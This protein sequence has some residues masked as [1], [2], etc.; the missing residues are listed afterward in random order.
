MGRPTSNSAR[1]TGVPPPRPS[2]IA[3]ARLP[4]EWV[5]RGDATY[6]GVVATAVSA[7]YLRCEGPF[8]AEL[9]DGAAW[10]AIRIEFDGDQEWF[11]GYV[12]I[13]ALGRVLEKSELYGVF[14]GEADSFNGY[15]DD[16]CTPVT[17]ED[18]SEAW[19]RPY[20]ERSLQRRFLSSLNGAS[21]SKGDPSERDGTGPGSSAG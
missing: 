10:V 8:L 13:D 3:T 21:D 15:N 16:R 11:G 2:R 5:G 12:A 7:R 18:F 6:D 4:G 17:R 20:A 9:V 14:E 19:N 1:S